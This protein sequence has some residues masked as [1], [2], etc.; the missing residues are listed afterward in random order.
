MTD[1]LSYAEATKKLGCSVHSTVQLADSGELVRVYPRSRVVAV[2]KLDSLSHD[3]VIL[4]TQ[5]PLK[6]GISN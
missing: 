5:M 4:E 3:L 1:L 6:S 2:A